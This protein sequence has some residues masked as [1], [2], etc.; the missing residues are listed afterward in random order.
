MDTLIPNL[1]Q[2]WNL[3]MW[4][5]EIRQVTSGST[6]VMLVECQTVLAY[7]MLSHEIVCKVSTVIT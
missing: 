7:M 6:V 5:L 2:V 1:S 4:T 3:P